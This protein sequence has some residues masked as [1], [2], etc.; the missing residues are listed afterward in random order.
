MIAA[1]QPN[2]TFEEKNDVKIKKENIVNSNNVGPT[3][4]IEGL[5][6]LGLR[7]PLSYDFRA[8]RLS[9]DFSHKIGAI[10][11]IYSIICR[12]RTEENRG[13]KDFE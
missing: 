2:I 5:N 9:R 1:K 13:G 7:C 3:D 6:D 4:V 8:G 11:L 12:R 10:R